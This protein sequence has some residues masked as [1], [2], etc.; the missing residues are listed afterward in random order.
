MLY[1]P[2]ACR[3]HDV[4][5]IAKRYL[6]TGCMYLTPPILFYVI[7]PMPVQRKMKQY[8]GLNVKIKSFL[9]KV[10]NPS[11]SVSKKLQSQCSRLGFYVNPFKT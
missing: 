4:Q 2:H 11:V 9:A 10:Q 7:D 8:K 1:S 3:A 5:K 6:L